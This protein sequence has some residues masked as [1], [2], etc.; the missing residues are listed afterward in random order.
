[1]LISYAPYLSIFFSR[2]ILS[3]VHGTWVSRPVFS[4]LYTMVWRFSNAPVTTVFYLILL[5]S[6][7]IV[8]LVQYIK[9]R[10]TFT[11]TTRV[12]LIWFFLPYFLMFLVSF[13]VPMFLDRYLVFLSFGFYFLIGLSISYMGKKKRIFFSLSILSIIL[14][15]GTFNPDV[16]N[17]RRIREVVQIINRLKT[18]ESVVL[19]CPA[20]L[21]L[22]FTY[23]YNQV[24]FQDY[25]NLRE[26]LKKEKIF[27]VNSVNEVDTSVYRKASNIIYFEEWATLVDKENLIYNG[28]KGR[29][30]SVEEYKIYENFMIYNFTP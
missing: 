21:E 12:M 24:Y 18:N 6:A 7:L 28:L 19:I 11:G 23:Y 25:K 4:D 14:M 5:F 3:S 13:K 20:W 30:K 22:G 10:V 1:V 29:F 16:D 2:L 27:P 26:N 9:S 15:A 8:Y 17:K